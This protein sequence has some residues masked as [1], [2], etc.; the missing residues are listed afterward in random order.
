[1]AAILAL[2]CASQPPQRPP[3]ASARGEIVAPGGWA[4]E[5][6]TESH[7]PEARPA[8]PVSP[9]DRPRL[10]RPKPQAQGVAPV[11]LVRSANDAIRRGQHERGIQTAK[12]A[13]RR[14]ERY[15]PAMVV[16][17]KGY[18][19]LRKYEL[20]SAILDIAAGIDDKDAGVH[21]LR[22]F[23]E[24]ARDNKPGA[25]ASFRKATEYDPNHAAAWNNLG[26]EY[27]QAKNYQEAVPAL[28]RAVSLAP[29]SAQ[30]HLNLGS[31][32]RGSGQYQKAEAAYRRA[33]ELRKEYAEAN[34]NLGIL[35][36]D[37]PEFPGLDKIGRL[38]AAIN[39][40][41]RYKELQ[42][43]RLAKDDPVDAYMEE[44]RKG[45]DRERKLRERERNRA[46]Q[47][48]EKEKE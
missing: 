17:A 25:L 39:Q 20:A 47:S 34:F 40:F 45:I 16:L 6:D 23:I 2:G 22:G 36:L 41:T 26:A 28:E 12:Q 3:A 31:A 9:K 43:Y 35:Y 13:L 38:S 30:A 7:G 32:Y 44:A 21:H 46:A 27:V 24:L 42:S 5:A 8:P 1:L 48:K 37:A 15:V 10:T 19:Q 18:Y 14:D 4:D 33:L 11:G 29:D